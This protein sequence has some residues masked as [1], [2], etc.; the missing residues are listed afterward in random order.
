MKFSENVDT[1]PKNRSLQFGGDL[2]PDLDPG[3]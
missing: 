1:G 3:I 2:D